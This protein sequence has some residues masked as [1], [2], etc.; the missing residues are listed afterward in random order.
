MDEYI[1]FNWAEDTFGAAAPGPI[2]TSQLSMMQ[3]IVNDFDPTGPHLLIKS[4]HTFF[5]IRTIKI[6]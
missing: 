4:V 2:F 5:F 6:G 3:R 1:G